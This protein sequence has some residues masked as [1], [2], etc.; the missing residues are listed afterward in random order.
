MTKYNSKPAATLGVRQKGTHV[1]WCIYARLAPIRTKIDNVH[2]YTA[3]NYLTK[4]NSL[5]LAISL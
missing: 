5:L 1:Q 4:K 3:I 2:L